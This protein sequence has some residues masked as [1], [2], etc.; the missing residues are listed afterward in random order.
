M[1][2]SRIPLKASADPGEGAAI[3]GSPRRIRLPDA[4]AAIYRAVGELSASYPGRRFTPDG[5]LV[6]SLGE[7]IAALE[8]DLDLH[9][10]SHPGHDARDKQGRDVQIKTT[11]GTSISMYATCD[12]LIVLRI[13]SPEWAEVVYDGDGGPVW[14]AAGKVQKNGQRTISFSTLRKLRGQLTI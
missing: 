7:V 3:P 11:G 5:H 14:D 4:V 1:T 2:K 8:F 9:K 13:C 10:S 6:G 12:R